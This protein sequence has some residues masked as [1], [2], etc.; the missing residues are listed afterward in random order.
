MP[1]AKNPLTPEEQRKRFEAEIRKRK[2]DGDFDPA[3]ADAM[4][5]AI[6]RKGAKGP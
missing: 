2:K 4:L 6:V 1:K 3:E 5:D